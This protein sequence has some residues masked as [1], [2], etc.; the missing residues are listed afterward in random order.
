MPPRR[1]ITHYSITAFN[2]IVLATTVLTG[3][4]TWIILNRV[5]VRGDYAS[6]FYAI[7]F[8]GVYGIARQSARTVEEPLLFTV[9]IAA[10]Y[11]SSSLLSTMIYRLSPFHPLASFPGPVL[12]RI[13][14]ARLAHISFEGRRHLI[15]DALHKKHG[16]FVRIG[17]NV[18]SIN[19]PS[20]HL[21]YGAG[22]S[23]EKS[24][25]YT[26]PGHLKSVALFFKQ[27]KE[28]HSN[29]KRMW[30]NAFTGQSMANYFPPL[31][32]R[33][34]Q[35]LKCIERR[36]GE[37]GIVELSRC[38]FHWS[39]DFMGEM[40]FG[41][42]NNLE[43]MK[44]GDPEGLLEGLEKAA[45]VLDT[46]GQIPWLMDIIWHLPV[47]KSMHGVRRRAAAMMRT[48]MRAEKDVDMCDLASHLLA[49]DPQTG[50]QLSQADL[51]LDALV[52]IQGGSDNTSITLVLALYFLLS[53]P[54]SYQ[55]LR[56]ELDK[57]FPDPAGHIEPNKL[58][59]LPFLNGV[60]NETLRLGS[61]FFLPRVVPSSGAV[62]SGK[63]IPAGTIVALAAYSQQTSP[64][65]F[66]PEPLNFI[67]E[68]WDTGRLGAGFKTEK[69]V[70]ASFSYGPYGCVARSFAYQELRFV[71][72][73]IVLT[74]DMRL[75]ES[76]DI[77]AF[78]DGILNMRT[79]VLERPLMV[80]AT[81]RPGVIFE[82]GV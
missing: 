2:P 31:E 63:N 35:L 64:E 41:G 70:L 79:T 38:L 22:H 24:H 67:P 42:S 16:P 68:R 80:I 76:F 34:W 44:T 32:R 49:E 81:K 78:R 1:M 73:R 14:S 37:D 48:R 10:I 20:G 69:S 27:N 62:I 50:Q 8:T 21:I 26:T 33:T 61:P 3:I 54:R 12:W 29:R 7:T 13:S 82:S 71:L 52:A 6:L 11:A 40:V 77:K 60:I 15:L 5:P 19:T 59:D 43:L 39:Y 51:D 47:G 58:L 46:F 30:T 28:M 74:L 45:I 75:P 72:T 9:I 53:C 23:M 18:L 4:L 25:A 56:A 66:S 57:T 17:P 65:N 55:D 36:T